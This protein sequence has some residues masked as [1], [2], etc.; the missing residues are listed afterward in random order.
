MGLQGPRDSVA[1]T[2]FVP[3]VPSW[4]RSGQTRASLAS[5][6]LP[7]SAPRGG[8]ILT[9]FMVWVLCEAV[10]SKWPPHLLEFWKPLTEGQIWHKTLS[11][12]VASAIPMGWLQ[13]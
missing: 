10:G 6:S 3:C 2:S 7:R 13:N 4:S 1:V 5:P 8:S 12:C 9:G 11:A